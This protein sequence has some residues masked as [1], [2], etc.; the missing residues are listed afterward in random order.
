[1]DRSKEIQEIENE[2]LE[3]EQEISKQNKLQASIRTETGKLKKQANTLK[4]KAATAL[5]SLQEAKSEEHALSTQ[6]VQSPKRI[7]REMEQAVKF[8]EATKKGCNEIEYEVATV[9]R[10]VQNVKECV[11]NV[12]NSLDIMENELKG[13]NNDHNLASK[14]LQEAVEKKMENEK[15][16]QDFLH[17]KRELERRIHYNEEK[18]SHHRQQGV[19]RLATVQQE[20]DFAQTEL[21]LVEKE[22]IDGLARVES[23]EADVLAI[24]AKIKEDDTAIQHEIEK[25]MQVYKKFENDIIEKEVTLM[26]A[27]LAI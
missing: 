2:C 10:R 18:L 17:K 1:M 5:L 9:K 11:E 20:L 8:L 19:R 14:E 26:T 13:I 27:A 16:V 3:I 24:E 21:A 15:V 25:M 12:Q 23:A 7:K 22:R 4:G 6:V